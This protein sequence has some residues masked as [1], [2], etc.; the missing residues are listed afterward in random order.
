VSTA[1]LAA[2]LFQDSTANSLAVTVGQNVNN[3]GCQV[4]SG[5]YYMTSG[6]TSATTFKIRCGSSSAGTMTLNGIAS[7]RKYAG[8]ASSSITITEIAA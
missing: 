2:A 6:T 1:D 7:A 5:L 4:V 3:G 8:V